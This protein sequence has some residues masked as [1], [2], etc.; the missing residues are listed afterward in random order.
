MGLVKSILH[1]FIPPERTMLLTTYDQVQYYRVKDHLNAAGI[2]HR[3][4]VG[5]GMR[6]VSRRAKYGGNMSQRYE[7]F[8]SKEDESKALKVIQS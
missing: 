1:F 6:E 7:L 5:G 8:V 3:S 2:R 4:K